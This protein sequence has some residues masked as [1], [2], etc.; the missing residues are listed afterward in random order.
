M[1]IKDNVNTVN[2]LLEQVA[3]RRTFTSNRERTSYELGYVIGILA[4]LMQDDSLI[5]HSVKSMLKNNSTGR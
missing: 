3:S 5:K 2:A 1:S 4:R